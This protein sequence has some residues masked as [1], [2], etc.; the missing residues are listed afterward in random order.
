MC[1]ENLPKKEG[2]KVRSARFG[3]KYEERSVEALKETYDMKLLVNSCYHIRVLATVKNYVVNAVFPILPV[4][5][6][7]QFMFLKYTLFYKQ[8]FYKQY[9]A[10]TGKKSSKR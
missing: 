1:I 10:E 9:Q 5:R 8:L 3:V 2:D 7:S 6:T 4:V